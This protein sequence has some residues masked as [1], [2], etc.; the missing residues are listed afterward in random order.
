MR[1][2]A[3][4]HRVAGR[5]SRVVGAGKTTLAKALGDRLSLPV[6]YEP[7]ADNA[8]LEDFYRDKSRYAF[9]LQVGPAGPLAGPAVA[10]NNGAR[11]TC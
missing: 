2:G 4:R 7:V 11:C 8:Y 10:H 5:L 1:A 3:G 9:P 6:Y